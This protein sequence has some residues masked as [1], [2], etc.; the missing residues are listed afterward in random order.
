MCSC[1]LRPIVLDYKHE[2]VT[3][4]CL[5]TKMKEN[6]RQLQK[7]KLDLEKNCGVII[8]STGLP[9]LRSLTCKSHS[10]T[11]KR[12]V[13]GRLKPFD[14]LL[15]ERNALM[16][17]KGVDQNTSGSKLFGLYRSIDQIDLSILAKRDPTPPAWFSCHGR[18][19]SFYLKRPLLDYK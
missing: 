10:L 19:L 13:Q 4:I 15:R 9:C 2:T 11:S 17:K 1:C 18:Q 7:Q 16:G 3:F 8:S 6:S 5:C 12:K 14:E